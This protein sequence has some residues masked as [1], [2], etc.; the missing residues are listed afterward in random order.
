MQLAIPDDNIAFERH[1]PSHLA[2]GRNVA[3]FT[4]LSGKRIK[5]TGCRRAPIQDHAIAR[6]RIVDPAF[7]DIQPLDTCPFWREVDAPE[8]W[9]A[10][11][12][13]ECSPTLARQPGDSDIRHFVR[14][15]RFVLIFLILVAQRRLWPTRQSLLHCLQHAL[16]PQCLLLERIDR[17][18]RKCIGLVHSRYPLAPAACKAH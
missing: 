6:N 16:K 15:Q 8:I 11:C 2:L 10:H 7:A 14:R 17:R 13:C 9:L 5:Q 1:L 12:A 4:S 3:R 18:A